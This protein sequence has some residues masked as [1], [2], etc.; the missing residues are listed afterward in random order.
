ME[1]QA[2]RD[3]V[4]RYN[5]ERVSGLRDRP[6]T[7]SSRLNESQQA[8]LRGLILRSP[9]PERDGVSSWPGPTSPI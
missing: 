5:A 4:M 7:R 1:R 9:D 3:A 2:L 6:R 8:A